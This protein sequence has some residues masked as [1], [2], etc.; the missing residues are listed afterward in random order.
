MVIAIME[1]E[2]RCN[3]FNRK[4]ARLVKFCVVTIH[5]I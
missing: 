4:Q 1:I 2:S 3:K 5:N